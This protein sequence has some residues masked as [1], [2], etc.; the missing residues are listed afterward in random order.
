NYW[1]GRG[2]RRYVSAKGKEYRQAV[3]DAIGTVEPLRGRLAVNIEL[4]M[5]DRRRRD[6]DN[7][8]KALFDALQAAGVFIDD[9][10]IDELCVKRLSI[11]APGA[12]DVIVHERAA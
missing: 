2:N 11:E 4:T 8:L 10:Q 5:P 3:E 12:A 9:E 7:V 1:R 6:I